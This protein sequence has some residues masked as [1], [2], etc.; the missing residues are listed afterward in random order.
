M[1][2]NGRPSIVRPG[3]VPN[4]GCADPL[5]HFALLMTF[6]ESTVVCAVDTRSPHDGFSREGSSSVMDAMCTWSTFT[7]NGIS[8]MTRPTS[9][10]GRFNASD[11]ADA[12]QNVW[13]STL[14]LVP[15]LCSGELMQSCR[16]TDQRF[17]QLSAFC[18]LSRIACAPQQL[19]LV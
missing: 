3:R 14:S 18:A 12:I 13:L 11:K 16:L 19:L 5:F 2:N 9:R 6:A 8:G 4:H 15:Q 7:C 1:L 10:Q 17:R